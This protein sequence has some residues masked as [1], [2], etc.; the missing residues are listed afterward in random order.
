[1]PTNKEIEVTLTLR[2]EASKR[3]QSFRS[4][5]KEFSK[6][7]KNSLAPI[8]QLR[9]AWMLT[10]IALA[11][12]VGTVLKGAQE[13]NKLNSE[14]KSLD[15]SAVR[16]GISSE[17]LSKRLYGFNIAT[18]NARIGAA[19][20]DAVMGNLK[21]T[22]TWMVDKGAGAWGFL[23]KNWRAGIAGIS[24][25]EAEKQLLAEAQVRR[26][27]SKEVIAIEEDLTNK[28]N[29]LTLSS[30]EYKKTL[31]NQELSHYSDIENE[32]VEKYRVA[33]EKLLLYS[34]Y[35]FVRWGDFIDNQ[36]HNY[37]GS[38]RTA[39]SS[40]IEDGFNGE[41]KSGK[42]YFISFGQSLNKIFA[43]AISEMIMRWAL[44]GE[45]I[46]GGKGLPQWLG[47]V[48]TLAGFLGGGGS[49]ITGGVGG[50]TISTGPQ[51]VAGHSFTTAW[52]PYHI[53]GPIRIPRAHLGLAADEIPIIA[54]R[55]EYVLSERGVAAAGG[56]SAMDRLNRGEF[57]GGLTIQI[58]YH[59]RT[60]EPKTFLD[61]LTQ[62]P[63]VYAAAS[64]GNILRN[65]DLR[66]IIQK[67]GG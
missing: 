59:I 42:E 57:P 6:E 28:T 1:M 46:G 50:K 2:D 51:S 11:A 31:L 19:Q 33:Q 61:K 25:P 9:R 5:V 16:L 20:A 3:I 41:L 43:Q 15:I 27:N 67:Y 58:H 10:S 30:F 29:Q 17:Q 52:S 7:T 26:R 62:Y 18:T 64:I 49:M 66:K 14:I 54:K 22:W 63:Q 39:M 24:T 34:Q 40:F 47:I 12:T 65:G 36:W 60:D 13:V 4:S 37:I 48:G 35:G 32:K 8:L 55:G 53:G 56:M 23:T 44:F 38:W 45:T 21:K